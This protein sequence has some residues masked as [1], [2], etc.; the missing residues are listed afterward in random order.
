MDFWKTNRKALGVIALGL[1]FL[2]W[3]NGWGGLDVE[4]LELAAGAVTLLTGAR[5]IDR[6]AKK[7]EE[8]GDGR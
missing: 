3:K 5:M 4:W 7:K 6:P 8:A 1:I 2:A